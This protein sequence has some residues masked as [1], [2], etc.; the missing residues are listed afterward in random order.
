MKLIK[1]TKLIV[2]VML[3]SYSISF[4]TSTETEDKMKNKINIS[5][6]NMKH[7]KIHLRNRN[8]EKSNTSKS[9]KEDPVQTVA[10]KLNSPI[11][12][13]SNILQ[14]A[15][16]VNSSPV[17][18][19]KLPEGPIFFAGWTKYFK[20]SNL[21]QNSDTPKQ[22]FKNNQYYEQMKL[23]PSANLNETSA[24]GN[25][26]VIS[27]Y[28]K[29]PTHFYTVLFKNNVNFVSS[30]NTQIQKTYDILN[31]ESI[32]PVQE[33]SGYGEGTTDNQNGIQDF[34]NFSEGFC[35]KVLTS[36]PRQETWILCTESDL[37]KTNFMKTLKQLKLQQQRDNGQVVLTQNPVAPTI[38][39]ILN[40]PAESANPSLKNDGKGNLSVTFKPNTQIT[41]GYW[42]VLQDW[43]QCS[44]KC[45][46][47]TSTLQR[48]CVPPKNGGAPCDGPL[49]MTKPCNTHP[50]PNVMG[51]NPFEL[52][53]NN[54]TYVMKPVVRVMPFSSRPQR[55]NKC[56]IKE[57]DLML[58]KDNDNQAQNNNPL[59]NTKTM[60]KMQIPVRVVM[61]NQTISIFAG[62]SYESQVLAF[63]LFDTFFK[64]SNSHKG[65]FILNES[66]KTAELCPFGYSTTTKTL[67]EWDY[68]FNLFKYQCHTPKEKIAAELD[69]KLNDKLQEKIN[70]A[71]KELLEERENEIKKGAEQEEA[72]QMQSVIKTTNQVALQAIQKELNLE[73]M[74][75]D[76][77]AQR[78]AR[79]EQDMLKKIEEE[80]KKTE[81]FMKAI[82]EREL[83]NQ[84][85]LRAKETQD[86]ISSIKE[87]AS[88]QVLIRRSQLKNQ[89]LQMRKKAERRK[90]RLAKE[91]LNVR[92]VMA[93]TMGKASKKGDATRCLNAQKS[94]T[95]R[96]N[97]CQASYADDY[98]GFSNCKEADDFCTLCCDNEF[99][100]LNVQDRL[101]CYKTVCPAG[102]TDESGKWVWQ[103][104]SK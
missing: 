24:D 56:V 60:P 25:N 95:D 66:G 11:G 88:Q 73:Q 103:N 102:A 81:C 49:I 94:Q 18:D 40:P 59:I 61:N 82:K 26:N 48:M 43:T 46:G 53:G 12:Q 55:Y 69:Q 64:H 77:E 5:E 93:E 36:R 79:E 65:C 41:D 6:G 14:T 63:T 52:N 76:E 54:S 42:I 83:E 37:E 50:C 72:N 39:Q 31:I 28:I 96:N 68:D 87:A 7:K 67:E 32:K 90:A 15:N 70:N 101:N 33:S 10:V 19:L 27:T 74:I 2:L 57:S 51:S 22:F 47:G 23:F 75:K 91:L 58:S 4:E 84:Y 71:K 99:G 17:L 1:L 3:I 30:R 78:E 38:S 45:G 9:G 104:K 92:N 20:Y 80:K 13:A 85:N 97:Y 29:S 98:A 35:F 8:K 89:I 44:L 100:E 86:E 62:D 34:G 16:S 21:D